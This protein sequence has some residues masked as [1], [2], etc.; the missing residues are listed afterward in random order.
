[1]NY[2]NIIKS[3]TYDSA[4]QTEQEDIKHLTQQIFFGD[5][6]IIHAE[7]GATV[8]LN[9]T[10]GDTLSLV[11]ALE[12]AGIPSGDAQELA[13]IADQEA[14]QSANEPFGTNAQQWLKDKL[15]AGTVEAWGIGKSVILGVITAALKKFY[16]LT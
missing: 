13:A 8:T 7:A 2:N 5:V 4:S 12:V 10:K 15:K 9:V 3:R 16:G 6:T 11:K 1:M 14:P